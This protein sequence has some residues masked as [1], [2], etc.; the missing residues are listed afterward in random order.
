MIS[1]FGTHGDVQPFAA[2]GQGLRAAGYQVALCTSAS[3]QPAVE[4]AGLSYA[5]MSDAA[6]QARAATIG[7]ARRAENGVNRAV[8]MISQLLEAREPA[9]QSA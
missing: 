2:L 9:V 8:A 1:T 6:I 7:A 4:G 3:Y 5:P